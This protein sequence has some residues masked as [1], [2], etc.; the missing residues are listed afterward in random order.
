MKIRPLNIG[1][2]AVTS[3]QAEDEIHLP[4]ERGL[5]PAFLPFHRPLDEILRRPSLDERLTA[6]M[7]PESLDPDLL[8]PAALADTRRQARDRFAGAARRHA[9]RKHDLFKAASALLEND[10]ELDEA[11]YQA[12]AALFRG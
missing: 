8:M 12:L 5:S 6:L 7:E 4:R 2:E 11:V 1:L 10:M 9:G 3:W